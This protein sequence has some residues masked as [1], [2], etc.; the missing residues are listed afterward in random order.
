M[1]FQ[2]HSS[3]SLLETTCPSTFCKF[4][5]PN[6]YHDRNSLPRM[7]LSI[8]I[9]ENLSIGSVDIE[10]S[11]IRFSMRQVPNTSL[12]I[13]LRGGFQGFTQSGSVTASKALQISQVQGAMGSQ[14]CHQKS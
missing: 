12:H 2:N 4:A 10:A 3:L 8:E 11:R 1:S 14:G 6:I 7:L 13:F 9:V 5:M